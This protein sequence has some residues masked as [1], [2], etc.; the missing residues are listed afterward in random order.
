MALKIGKV[1]CY[2]LNAV[3]VLVVFQEIPKQTNHLKEYLPTFFLFCYFRWPGCVDHRIVRVL[4]RLL[5][6]YKVSG[7]NRL[8]GS[9]VTKLKH[10]AF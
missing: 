3:D 5:Q 6:R 8:D 10:Y 1:L 7:L 2:L 4:L 9:K